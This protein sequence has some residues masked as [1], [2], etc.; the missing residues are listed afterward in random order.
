MEKAIGVVER[1]RQAALGAKLADHINK[2]TK[3]PE[4]DELMFKLNIA[5]GRHSEAAEGAIGMAFIEQVGSS[6]SRHGYA[7]TAA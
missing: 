4:Q 2:E 5:L 6:G 1:S 7:E 3:P